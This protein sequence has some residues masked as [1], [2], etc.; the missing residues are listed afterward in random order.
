MSNIGQG[1]RIPRAEPPRYDHGRPRDDD[2][3][4]GGDDGRGFGER[5][6]N[7]RDPD[8]RGFADTGRQ[9]QGQ[10]RGQA[11][12]ARARP[13]EAEGIDGAQDAALARRADDFRRSLH[14]ALGNAGTGHGHPAHAPA[15]SPQEGT[16]AREEAGA[17]FSP[18][19]FQAGA[20]QPGSGQSG[21]SGLFAPRRDESAR[22]DHEAGEQAIAASGAGTTLPLFSAL[23]P[24]PEQP[25]ADPAGGPRTRD[26]AAAI[27]EQ[28]T[29]AMRAEGQAAAGAGIRIDVAGLVAGLDAITI[30]MSATGID[31]VL[32]GSLELGAEAQALADRLSRRF[33]SRP[34]RVLASTEGGGRADEH[35]RKDDEDAHGP[36]V[37]PATGAGG[38]A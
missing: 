7:G 35:G 29:Q 9:A 14:A 12:D 10:A 15:Q 8:G 32:S 33:G 20:P 3:F 27:E 5:G 28:V 37:R 4:P 22:E 21:L 30:R 31:V 34:V 25:V 13:N 36:A 18:G 16:A 1:L 38:P 6:S 19:L 26:I 24:L 23:Q 11:E 2:A 17:G